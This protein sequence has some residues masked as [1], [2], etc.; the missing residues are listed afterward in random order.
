MEHFSKYEVVFK[1]GCINING[2]GIESIKYYNM[3]NK[4]SLYVNNI[5]EFKLGITL[6]NS[7]KAHK[8]SIQT[9][10]NPEIWREKVWYFL[11]EVFG[12]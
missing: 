1:Q 2:Y 4:D 10:R 12:S 7:L 3:N 6:E 8:F 9:T 11:Y 5:E